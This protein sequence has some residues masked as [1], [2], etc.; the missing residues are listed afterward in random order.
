MFFPISSFF[1]GILGITVTEQTLSIVVMRRILV[2]LFVTSFWGV[3]NGGTLH[4]PQIN[5]GVVRM[6]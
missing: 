4:Y 2:V 3:I 5:Y 6:E 1:L